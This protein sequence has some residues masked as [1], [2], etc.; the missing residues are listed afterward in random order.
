[1]SYPVFNGANNNP[2]AELLRPYLQPQ[3]EPPQ[4]APEPQQASGYS[5]TKVYKIE[6]EDDIKYIKP[7]NTGQE[8]IIYC[9]KGKIMFVARYNYATEKPD[10][11]KYI[12]EGNIELFKKNDSS[13]DMSQIANALVLVA[14]KFDAVANK[15]DSMDSRIQE[16]ATA[17]PSEPAKEESNRKPNG[18]FK[19]KGEK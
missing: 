6:K 14:N 5:G 16:L 17:K 19:K 4:P 3:P 1:M 10:Y 2:L 13:A 9:E 15:L 8:Q 11:E 7:D 18:Q 12:S